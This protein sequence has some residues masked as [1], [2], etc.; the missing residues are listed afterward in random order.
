MKISL[1]LH[2]Q[3][4]V[5][6][7]ERDPVQCPVEEYRKRLVAAV[8]SDNLNH[9]HDGNPN[10]TLGRPCS[11]CWVFFSAILSLALL[12]LWLPNWQPSGLASKSHPGIAPQ[13]LSA[14]LMP[15]FPASRGY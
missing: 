3:A 8:P 12:P 11:I 6:R 14:V 5:V 13:T 10:H 15:M 4:N 7:R 2:A 1:S 9:R